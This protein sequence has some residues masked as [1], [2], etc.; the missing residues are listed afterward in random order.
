MIAFDLE[1]MQATIDD[2]EIDA[3]PVAPKFV[4]DY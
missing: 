3:R 4:A 1:P 2:G